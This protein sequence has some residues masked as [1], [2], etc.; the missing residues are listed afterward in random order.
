MINPDKL[1]NVTVLGAA[2]KMGSGILLLTAVEI[3]DLS[4]Q[5]ENKNLD[6]VVN[7]IDVSSFS[8]KGV[9]KYIKNQVI[10]IAEKKIIDLRKWYAQR[11]DL[12]ENGE[13]IEQYVS[14]VL[15]TIRTS[16]RIESAY[17]STLIFEAI[18][19]DP[20]LKSRIFKEIDDASQSNP[21]FF[22]NTSSIP[23]AELETRS[24][25]EGRIIGFH[26]Y[27]PPAVQKLVEIIKTKQTQPEVAEFALEFA[28]KLGKVIVE[29]NDFAGFIGNGHFMRDLLYGI[30]QAEILSAQIGFTQ[31][32]VA[33]NSI[34]A[35]YLIRPMGIFQLTDYVGIDVCSFILQ[36][37]NSFHHDDLH[38]NLLDSLID[39]NIKGGQHPDGS[40]KDGFFKYLF[41]KID[42]VYDYKSEN[43]IKIADTLPA[44]QKFLE[45]DTTHFPV[46]KSVIKNK[47]KQQTLATH[48]KLLNASESTG[49]K[50]AIK[51]L[52]NSK[53]IGLQLIAEGVANNATDVNTVM[54]T[55]FFH[56]Y[57][58]IHNFFE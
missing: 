31:A 15:A 48:F 8:L 12:V 20:N 34:T 37:M 53:D 11:D 29:S 23:I 10:K 14:D 57:G 52:Q 6:F 56:A 47:D 19:E 16:T 44:V 45:T 22:T 25:I 42:A 13:I 43:Y 54:L 39:L 41:G 2:G 38:S 17:N 50:L 40:Q 3:T 49:N 30:K 24:K 5:P 26:F 7:A 35:D 1:R 51:Y 21:W 32:I 27:N 33:V 46:W 18:K 36:V 55:G 58:P 4:L 9:M 28:R